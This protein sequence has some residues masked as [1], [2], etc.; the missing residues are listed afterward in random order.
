[1][2]N[3]M[4]I[5]GLNLYFRAYLMDPSLSRNGQPVGGVKG[6]LKMLQKLLRENK[7]DKIFFCWDGP[8]SSSRRR[9]INSNYKEGR[10]PIRLNRKFG[11][12]TEEQEKENR[13]W[14]YS[15]IVEYLN[16]LPIAQ[17]YID[18][19]EADD[20][21]A[22]LCKELPNDRKIIISNDKDYFQLLDK[23]THLYRPCKSEVYDTEKV[24]EEFGIHPTN[25]A[26]ARAIVGDASDNLPGAKGV[27]LKTVASKF[28]ELKEA[29]T[30]FL[31]EI[32]K[33]CETVSKPLM[34]HSS[35]LTSRDLIKE[36]Y[37]LMQLYSPPISVQ[38]IKTIK[39][40]ANSYPN[41]F[42]K[43]NVRVMMMQDGIGDYSWTEMFS[44]LNKIAA[45]EKKNDK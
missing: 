14:Q 18:H 9:A 33:K 11:E 17:V 34:A 6:S 30:I 21:I 5:D 4:L 45:T 42:N 28:P 12:L 13:Y 26:L 37:D 31:S 22:V 15:R 3:I 43:T 41:G 32:C 10:K 36:N 27:G 40:I 2:K 39:E 23:N 35:I 1:M 20:V 24:I 29:K 8:K 25:F 7:P 44:Y 16:E 19:T 38:D